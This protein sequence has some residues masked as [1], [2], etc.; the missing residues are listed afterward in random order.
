[1]KIPIIGRRSKNKNLPPPPSEEDNELRMG[2]FEHLEEL[3]NRL[4]KIVVMVIIGTFIGSLISGDM[5]EYLLSPYANI[6]PEE[7]QQLVVLGPTGAVVT[8]FKVALMIGGIIGIPVITYQV[9]MFVIPGLTGKEKRYLFMALPAITLLFLVGVFFAWFALIPPAIGFLESF[10][11]DI[12]RPEWTAENYISFVTALIFWMG[13]A[14]ET[15]L[16]FFVL[17]LL[18]IVSA[19]MLIKNWRFAVVGTAIAAALI[20]PTI[21]PVNMFLVMGPLLALYVLSI[22]LVMVGRRISG[23]SR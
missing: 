4:F 16:V 5:L 11:A 20:T 22:F 18:G 7:T 17:S 14:F 12:F 13:V 23:I 10:Q 19:G 21:D 8:Y 15:P 1:M 2:F 3:R 9:L 6:N